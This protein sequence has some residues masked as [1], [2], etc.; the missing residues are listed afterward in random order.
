MKRLPINV[1]LQQQ[2]RSY[3]WKECW[4]QLD[5]EMKDYVRRQ[6]QT[7][8]WVQLRDRLWRLIY[9]SFSR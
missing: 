5:N 6:L 3:L 4:K 9:E 8:L 7:Q 1:R 2:V